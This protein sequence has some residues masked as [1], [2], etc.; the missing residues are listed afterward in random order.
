MTS[1]IDQPAVLAALRAAGIAPETA[2]SAS[3]ASWLEAQL[4]RTRAPFSALA[5][6]AEPAGYLVSLEALRP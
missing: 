5:F 6:E 2:D 1:R 3:A 4:A